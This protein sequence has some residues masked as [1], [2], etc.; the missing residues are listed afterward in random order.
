MR[1]EDQPD[2]GQQ[3]MLCVVLPTYN[4][5]DNI[6]HVISDIAS[7]DVQGRV[8]RLIFV[9]DNSSDG[10]AGFVKSFKDATPF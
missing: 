5:I 4:E 1:T 6:G 3:P 10:T 7:H 2:K 8:K 9:D